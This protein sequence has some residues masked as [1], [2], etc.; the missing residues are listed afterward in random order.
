MRSLVLD[1]LV[2]FIARSEQI[3]FSVAIASTNRLTGNAAEFIGA[4]DL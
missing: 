3:L 2:H 4:N 1:R